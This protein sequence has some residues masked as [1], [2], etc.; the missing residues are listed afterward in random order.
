[1]SETRPQEATR[2]NDTDKRVEILGNPNSGY[3]LRVYGATLASGASIK[4]PYFMAVS[5]L[6]SPANIAEIPNPEYLVKRTAAYVWEGQEDNRFP[7]MKA[8]AET[9]LKNMLEYETVYTDASNND[10]VY[11]V[12]QTRYNFRVGRD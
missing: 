2:F 7:Q 4:V 3:V 12:E 11:T 8:E 6:A 5:S 9:I 1:M 10:R